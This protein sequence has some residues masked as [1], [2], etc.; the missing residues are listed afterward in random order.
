MNGLESTRIA[1]QS[2]I[3]AII[4]D[5]KSLREVIDIVQPE[6]FFFTDL[7]GV[8]Q[9]ILL[10]SSQY[11]PID[12]VTVLAALNGKEGYVENE[13]KKLLMSCV[14]ITPSIS[15]VKS[16]A[17]IVANSHKARKLKE[18]GSELALDFV[19]PESATETANKF[20]DDIYNII[21]HQKKKS[22]KDIGNVGLELFD[23]YCQ[24]ENSKENR[25]ETGYKKVDSILK[26]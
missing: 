1:E 7:R 18:I 5:E 23:I 22:L 4:L 25:S 19:A 15:N 26:E 11:K 9:E 3:G 16:Y 14:E 10:L 8:F 12:F 6:D 21:T 2:V 24:K 20:F 13:A 17:E